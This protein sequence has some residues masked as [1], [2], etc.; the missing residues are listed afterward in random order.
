MLRRFRTGVIVVSAAAGLTLLSACSGTT[1]PP[2][3][4]PGGGTGGGQG[5]LAAAATETAVKLA[6]T[7]V[8]ELGKVLTD[9]DGHTLYRFD[10]DTAKPPKS[11]CVDDCAKAWPPLLSKGDVQLD[12]VDKS[13]VG[14]VT[15]DDGTEQVTV[16]GWPLY[17]YAK[18][19]TPGDATGQGV[20]GTWF[21]ATPQGGKAKS[22]SD[23]VKLSAGEVDGVGAAVTDQDGFTLYLFTKD[24]KKPSKSTC[25]GD[26]AKLWPP[27][28]TT[29][30]V[31]LDGIDAKLLGSVKRADGTT[32]ATLGGWPLYRYSKDTAPGQAN[33][34]GVKGTWFVIEPNGCKSGTTASTRTAPAK[35]A[36]SAPA[37]SASSD[38]YSY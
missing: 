4:V 38:P 37:P 18:D 6:A 26:C 11:A 36:T 7:D 29:G 3:P 25:D 16:N 20:N 5:K 8:G 13:L 21:A 15:R 14:S 12:G 27:V 28:L 17:T 24:S 2:A 23:T 19:A 33:G 32:Q 35:P 10:K 1:A 30:D 9:G 34:M 22:T 31:A